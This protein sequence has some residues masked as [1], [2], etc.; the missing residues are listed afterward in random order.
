MVTDPVCKMTIDESKAA[1]KSEDNG[2][3][4]CAPGRKAKFDAN[5]QQYA[6][7]LP[8]PRVASQRQDPETSHTFSG[9]QFSDGRRPRPFFSFCNHQRRPTSYAKIAMM[10]SATNTKPITMKVL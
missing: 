6:K 2:K 1:G 7:G 3:T 4:C 5:P 10:R 9:P 8:P